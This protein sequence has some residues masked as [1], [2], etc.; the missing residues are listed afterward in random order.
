MRINRIA[1][2][3]FTSILLGCTLNGEQEKKLNE[4][5]SAY[6]FA[7]NECQVISYVAFTYPELVASYR[8]EGDSL[9]K[10]HFNCNKDSIY[11]DDPTLRQTVKEGNSIHVLYDMTLYHESSGKKDDKKYPL[12][13][14]S[15]DNGK[16]WFFMD[17]SEYVD[18]SR[19]PKLV[20][21]LK[22]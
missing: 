3:L 15:D 7:R 11:L 9:F 10:E 6:V 2:F 21:L 22:D 4:S 16:S 8:A 19:L 18:K 1:A 14:I 20:R 12:I 17:K 13:G 5:F